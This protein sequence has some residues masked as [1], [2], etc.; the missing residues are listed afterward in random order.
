VETTKERWCEADIYRFAGEI[1]LMSAEP[2]AAKAEA[3]FARALAV[4][5]QQ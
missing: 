3:Y 4:A 5:R 1:A 2:G